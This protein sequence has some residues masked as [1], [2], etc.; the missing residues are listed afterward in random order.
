MGLL[1][2]KACVNE[3]L[4]TSKRYNSKVTQVSQSWKDELEQ[5]VRVMIFRKV[6]AHKG[7]KTLVG[8]KGFNSP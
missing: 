6:R 1:N 7:S 8:G 2:M 3:A 4:A 5:D